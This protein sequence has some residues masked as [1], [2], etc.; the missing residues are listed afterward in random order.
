MGR[1]IQEMDAHGEAQCYV[2]VIK[3]LWVGRRQTHENAS[4]QVRIDM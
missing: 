4:V 3:R 2:E 1:T